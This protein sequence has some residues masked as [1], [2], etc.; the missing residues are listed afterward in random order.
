[1]TLW[2]PLRLWDVGCELSF[3]A[4]MGLIVLVRPMEQG[5]SALLSRLQSEDRPA[6]VVRLLSGPL[7]VTMGAQLAVWPIT[8][9]YFHRLSLVSPRTNFLIIPGQPL[10]MIIGGLA[11]ILGALHPL[12]GQPIAWV[13][14]LFLTY[15]IRVVELTARLPITAIEL[16]G[17]S[18]R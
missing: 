15:T 16:G 13:A 10:V 3:A 14:W 9:Y 11:T 8:L 12:L 7:F 4:G 1:M 2:N 5:V 6:A 18:A 17:F